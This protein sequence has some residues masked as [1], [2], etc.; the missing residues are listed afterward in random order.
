MKEVAIETASNPNK[1][2]FN[3]V[4]CRKIRLQTKN[5]KIKAFEPLK[6]IMHIG[7]W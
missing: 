4:D 1:A 7:F 3:H 5:I 2:L 6:N